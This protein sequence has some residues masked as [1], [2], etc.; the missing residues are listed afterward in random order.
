MLRSTSNIAVV[1]TRRAGFRQ[2]ISLFNGSQPL[3]YS[4]IQQ[5]SLLHT[6]RSLNKEQKKDET[7]SD[8]KHN[9][10]EDTKA[11]PPPNDGRSPLSIFRDTFKKEWEKSA[12]LQDNIKTLQDASGR[13]GESE[14]YKKARE[15]YIKAQKG[16]TIVGKT[17]K[18]TGEAVEDIAVKA[19]DSDIG[20]ATR[21][22]AVKTAKKI[23]E[24]L[25]P[26]R[27]TKIYKDVS[28]VIDDGDSS[29]YG[30]FITKE[31]RRLKREKALATGE[32]IR[33]VK[34]NEEAGTALV[35]TNIESKE[36]LGKKVEDFKEKTV[37]G[38]SLHNAKVK[39]W[40]ESENPLIVFLRKITGK[41]GR[42]FAE[43]ESG[44]VY[45][46]F[47]LM[48]PNF[49]NASFTKHLREYVVPEILEAYIR[50]DEAV[51]KKWFSEAPFNVYA[52]Q[53]KMFKEK[54]IFSEG[55]ILDIRGVEIVSAKLLQPQDIPV[56]VVGCRAQ[57]INVYKKIKT[58]EIAAG[59][60]DNILMSSYAMVFTRDPEQIDDEETEGWKILEFVRGGSRQF[61]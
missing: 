8:N 11:P 3:E 16:S 49:N 12:E 14:A 55:R 38:R 10:K 1:S 19:W 40:D 54:A 39:L 61:T 44:R 43:T 28:E 31:E 32:R 24:T 7:K 15:A 2:V 29:K 9:Q 27:Q 34:S 13:L 36:S 41:I 51:L 53:Q 25:E 17:L 47:K 4:Y 30:G 18:K 37:V 22:T 42:F 26:V 21:D 56:L 58:G 5:V 52:A 46:Q 45:T 33:A 23:D 50:G 57:E 48:D 6:S 60:E 20:K 35:A 59:S